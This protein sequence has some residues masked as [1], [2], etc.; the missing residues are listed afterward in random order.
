MKT[1]IIAIGGGA[2]SIHND[3]YPIEQY[4]LLQT[5]KAEP[6]VC[7]M[8]TASG[9]SDESLARFHTVFSRFRCKH[10]HL[11]LSSPPPDIESFLLKQDVIY[12][13]GGPFKNLLT[14]WQACNLEKILHKAWQQGIILAGISSGATCWFEAGMSM[15]AS[16]D[17]RSLSALGFLQGSFCAHYDSVPDKR[18]RYCEL[19]GKGIIKAGIACEDDVALHYIDGKL[20]HVLSG[21]PLGKAYEIKQT[22]NTWQ[23][24]ALHTDIFL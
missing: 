20:R 4:V 6:K 2:M 9:D 7:F 1:Q 12:V 21:K 13:G 23:E 8:A 17:F 16:D 19:V 5:G 11:A 15:H 24:I 3:S 14:A 22:G 10:T 18:L